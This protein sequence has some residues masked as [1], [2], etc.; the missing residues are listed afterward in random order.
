MVVS[1]GLWPVPPLWVVRFV[2]V[3]LGGFEPR[4]AGGM[5]RAGGVAVWPLFGT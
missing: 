4:A 1:A 5:S 3:A 2:W